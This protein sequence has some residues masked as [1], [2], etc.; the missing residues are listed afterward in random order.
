VFKEFYARLTGVL[1]AILTDIT[2]HLVSADVISPNKDEEVMSPTTRQEQTKK[3]LIAL[4]GQISAG[5]AEPLT[6]LLT[7]MQQYGN[8]VSKKLSSE[9]NGVLSSRRRRNSSISQY[10]AQGTYVQFTIA[11]LDNCKQWRS[12]RPA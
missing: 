7:I 2:P 1:S 5:Y 12:Q 11:R 6:K 9:I 10:V 4:H 8:D 3:V